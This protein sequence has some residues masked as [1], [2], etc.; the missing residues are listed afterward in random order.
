MK[1]WLHF[2]KVIRKCYA[3]ELLDRFIENPSD[4]EADSHIDTGESDDDFWLE[5]EER[6][7]KE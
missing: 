4:D 3:D 6:A 7:K 5:D 2:T 1:L